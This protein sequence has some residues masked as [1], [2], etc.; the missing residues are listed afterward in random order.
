[1]R[2]STILL[3]VM[4]L[5]SSAQLL[6]PDP[7]TT[8]RGATEFNFKVGA[9]LVAVSSLAVYSIVNESDLLSSRS[10]CLIGGTIGVF[11][12]ADAIQKRIDN[13]NRKFKAFRKWKR[14][15]NFRIIIK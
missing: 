13:K 12:L 4:S 10:L 14:F 3:L 9:D 1:M 11:F 15:K 8:M 2:Y 6:I 5:N 7:Y